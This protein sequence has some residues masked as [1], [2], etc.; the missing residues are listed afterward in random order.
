MPVLLISDLAISIV[1][2]FLMPLPKYSNGCLELEIAVTKRF[3]ASRSNFSDSESA[4]NIGSIASITTFF[5]CK[6]IGKSI[7]V[8]PFLSCMAAV[9]DS[10]N[11]RG[12][13]SVFVI[14][15][16]NFVTGASTAHESNPWTP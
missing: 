8:G 5:R 12:T 4:F 11:S 2:E 9:A 14:R 1:F 16:D 6:S 10:C 7:C 15:L 3:T 13:S